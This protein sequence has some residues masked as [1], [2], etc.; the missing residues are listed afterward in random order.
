MIQKFAFAPFLDRFLVRISSI[1]V[2][3]WHRGK[4]K[5]FK[6]NAKVCLYPESKY[7]QK[8]E[9]HFVQCTHFKAGRHAFFLLRSWQ[10]KRV[11][12]VSKHLPIFNYFKMTLT[13]DICKERPKH[14]PKAM[15]KWPCCN[16]RFGS[17]LDRFYI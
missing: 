1:R 9:H 16:D 13:E 3:I 5:I 10:N 2:K 14:D 4:K 6:I 8:N 17:C 11:E 15:Q 7:L 12:K